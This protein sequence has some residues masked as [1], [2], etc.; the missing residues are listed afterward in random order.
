[1][2]DPEPSARFVGATHEAESLFIPHV[3]GVSHVLAQSPDLVMVLETVGIFP[4]LAR[5]GMTVAARMASTGLELLDA[6]GHLRC[7]AGEGLQL[8]THVG[9]SAGVAGSS[10][11]VVWVDLHGPPVDLHVEAAGPWV[12]DRFSRTGWTLAHNVMAEAR[13]RIRP[14]WPDQARDRASGAR[15]GSFMRVSTTR[16]DEDRPSSAP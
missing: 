10:H 12:D 13:G 14:L 6:L 3:W 2:S 5:L 15:R 1:M 7:T 16:I 4:N 9:S 11:G 8:L